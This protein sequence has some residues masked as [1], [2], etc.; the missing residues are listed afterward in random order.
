MG[1]N[2]N[3]LNVHVQFKP[4]NVDRFNSMLIVKPIKKTQRPHT[5]SEQAYQ[6]IL[7]DR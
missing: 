3:M 7:T 5:Q 4:Y 1:S 6:Y 2:S